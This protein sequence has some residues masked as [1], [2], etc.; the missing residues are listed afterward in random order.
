METKKVLIGPC[1]NGI[2]FSE[3]FARELYKRIG[4]KYFNEPIVWTTTGITATLDLD[5]GFFVDNTK[6]GGHLEFYEIIRWGESISGGT[7][8][9]LRADPVCHQ[10]V[11]EFGTE[12]FSSA[13]Y[14][15]HKF[16]EIPVD[17]EFY[18]ASDE[19]GYEW[20]AEKHRTW[21]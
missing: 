11:E 2:I 9:D 21:D 12:S 4:D 19:A 8:A 18:V 10:I 14:G 17:V 13:F 16:V 5:G 3:K 20:V 7:Q 6:E 15:S 1:V